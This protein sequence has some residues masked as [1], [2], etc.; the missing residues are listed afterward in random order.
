MNWGALEILGFLTERK[1]AGEEKKE[2]EEGVGQERHPPPKSAKPPPPVKPPSTYGDDK[3]RL[4]IINE[5]PE[6]GNGKGRGKD[7]GKSKG[8][9]DPK[10]RGEQKKGKTGQ[11]G[12]QVGDNKSDYTSYTTREKNYGPLKV[13][14]GNNDG[15]SSNWEWWGPEHKYVYTSRAQERQPERSDQSFISFKTEGAPEEAGLG[16]L[17]KR[18]DSMLDFGEYSNWAYGEIVA[19]KPNYTA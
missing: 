4:E 15:D 18:G 16:K 13:W 6:K 10:G 19:L 9:N 5:A 2:T 3:P 7:Q 8:T 1:E 14:G 11:T 17:T 12:K